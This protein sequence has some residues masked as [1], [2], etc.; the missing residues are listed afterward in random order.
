MLI[1]HEYLHGKGLPA[2]HRRQVEAVKSW[3]ATFFPTVRAPPRKQATSKGK[4]KSQDRSAAPAVTMDD[5]TRKTL[6]AI[7]AICA[8]GHRLH[9]AA[10][11][12]APHAVR[13]GRM[14]LSAAK[15]N[16]K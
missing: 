14:A 4:K 12:L 9:T 11:F 16:K 10:H 3:T 5:E 6:E 8:D 2:E 1:A 15:E 13:F 7:E